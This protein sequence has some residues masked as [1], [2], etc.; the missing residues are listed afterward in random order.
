MFY[1]GTFYRVLFSKPLLASFWVLSLSGLIFTSFFQKDV[2]KLMGVKVVEKR[3]PYFYA[4]MPSDINTSYIKR[5]LV[6]IPGVEAVSLMAK[7]Q[8]TQQVKAVLESTDLDWEG[9]LVDLNFAG[10]KID[11]SPDLKS[12]SQN[13]IRSYLTRLTGEKDVTLGAIKEPLT[14]TLESSKTYSLSSYYH[15]FPVLFLG[16]YV[17]TIFIMRNSLG[18]ES[19]IIETYQRKTKVFEKSL[20]YGQLPILALLITA[21][22]L[23]GSWGVIY[24]LTFLGGLSLVFIRLNKVKQWN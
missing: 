16:L 11:L 22:V 8:I 10:L 7:E 6:D 23:Q 18:S 1:I 3:N 20:F 4:V 9:D 24:F 21:S 2:T 15:Y 17:I 5:K 14:N 13:L 12:R 19:F